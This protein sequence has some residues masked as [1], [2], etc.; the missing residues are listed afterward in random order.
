MAVDTS[1][2][3][4][5]PAPVLGGASVAAAGRSVSW[6]AVI[7]GA[8]AA[9]ALSLIL[10][11]LGTGLGLSSASPWVD[12]GASA[13]ALGMGAIA[14]ITFM[15][16]AAAALGGYLAG[17]L[18]PHWDV[19]GDE[20]YFRDTAHGFL[21]WCLATLLTA[22]LLTS[23]IASIVGTGAQVGA[24]AV[25]GGVAG[26]GATAATAA[27][28]QAEGSDPT[29]YFVDTLFRRQ[30]AAAP[31]PAEGDARSTAEVGR[32]FANALRT[33]SLPM[34]DAQYAGALVAQR[35]GLSPADAQKRVTEVY[36]QMQTKMKQAETAA[37]EAADKARKASAYAS[38]WLFVSLLAGAF[39]AS[40]AATWGGRHRDRW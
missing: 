4:P 9:A 8:L 38:L 21:A 6:R 26:V 20:V 18:R 32:I 33:G 35:T 24:T 3:V 30:D 25:A 22:A 27:G 7:A 12:R 11:V 23:T 31:A 36:A 13:Q 5:R 16:I 29:G 14:W 40:L 39:V 19:P 28:K 34:A 17:R 2:L 37:R 15:Q 1:A 10:L